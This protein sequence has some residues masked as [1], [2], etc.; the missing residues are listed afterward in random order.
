MVIYHKLVKAHYTGAP[1]VLLINEAP[2]PQ[3]DKYGIPLIGHQ[4]SILYRMLL[5]ANYKWAKDWVKNHPSFS[6]PTLP[7]DEYIH[8]NEGNINNLEMRDEFLKLRA[9]YIACTNSFPRWPQPENSKKKTTSPTENDVLDIINIDRL[10]KEISTIHPKILL[11]CG[12]FAWL[13]CMGEEI[14]NPAN[15]EGEKVEGQSFCDINDR[16]K[17]NFDKI[18]YLGHTRRWTC[19]QKVIKSV[20]IQIGN[21]LGWDIK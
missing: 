19:N 20:F 3:E 10:R 6:W 7:R 14:S 13:A 12:K 2:G 5:L 9:H 11:I 15:H 17:Y 21:E 8:L 1:P 16:L 4:G 18:W